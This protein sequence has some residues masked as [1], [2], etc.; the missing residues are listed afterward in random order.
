MFNINRFR[1]I[2]ATYRD[3]IFP[4]NS[5]PHIFIVAYLHVYFHHPF[6]VNSSQ[7]PAVGFYSGQ[8]LDKF[9]RG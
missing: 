4:R 8:I 6:I 2:N 1:N 3:K 9:F 7:D 5:R